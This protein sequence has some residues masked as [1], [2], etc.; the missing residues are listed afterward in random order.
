MMQRRSRLKPD[1]SRIVQNPPMKIEIAEEGAA[2]LY[3]Y[4][5]I[6]MSFEVRRVFDVTVVNDGLGGFALSNGSCL[7]HI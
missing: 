5:R 4:A 1:V 2:S 3:D 7:L 6:R